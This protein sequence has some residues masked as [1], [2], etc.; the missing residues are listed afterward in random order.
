[1]DFPTFASRAGDIAQASKDNSTDV[2]AETTAFFSEILSADTETPEEDLAIVARFIQGDIFP[3]WNQTKLSVGPKFV[4]ESIARCAAENTTADDVEEK[5]AFLGDIS[6]VAASYDF[7]GQQNLLSFGESVE[8]TLTVAEIARELERLAEHNGSGSHDRRVNILFGLLNRC[9]P[10]EA[11]YLV[12]IVLGELHSGVTEETVKQSLADVLDVS[13]EAIEFALQVTNDYQE[14]IETAQDGGVGALQNLA[15]DLGRPIQPMLAEP[16]TI[17]SSAREWDKVAAE[18]KHDGARA[19]IHYDGEDAVRIFSRNMDD[20]TNALPDVVRYVTENVDKP[21]ILDGEVVAVDDDGTPQP[22]QNV[23]RRF[24]QQEDVLALSKKYP[25]RYVAFDCLY[26]DDEELLDKS[27]T[28]RYEQLWKAY[29]HDRVT[30]RRRYTST[31]SIAEFESDM[32]EKGHEG[33]MLKN[34]ASTYNAGERGPNWR[35][36][37][38]DV[39]TLELAITGAEWNDDTEPR[40]MD[41]FL[42]SGQTEDGFKTVGNV[43]AGMSE[44][45]LR[46]LT[47]RLEP[48]IRSETGI[49][50]DIQPVVV[51]EVGYETIERSPKYTSQFALRY[52]R[53]IGLREDQNIDDVSTLSR[54]EE[55]T[56]KYA[57]ESQSGN[58]DE[59]GEDSKETL[60][61]GNSESDSVRIIELGDDDVNIVERED[62]RATQQDDDDDDDES[63]DRIFAG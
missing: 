34:A 56:D 59:E 45:I 17:R 27:L 47:E 4:Y 42:V 24:R 43:E 37:K 14:V 50:L 61:I 22:F 46:M 15:I 2:Q 6:D 28:E 39:E 63:D 12:Q 18:V 33:I 40:M 20:V 48:Y 9:S 10:N 55:L 19:Q 25:V 57:K 1:M 62:S 5:V 54:I 8:D 41:S 38:P 29:P 35:K 7:S 31:K 51:I 11:R 26:Y 16:G 52:P 30:N 49:A 36:V 13:P 44:E 23:L 21:V 32:L 53:F 58:G 3:G 60:A